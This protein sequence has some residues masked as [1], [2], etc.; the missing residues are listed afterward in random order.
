[1][2]ILRKGIKSHI[3]SKMVPLNSELLAL[4]IAPIFSNIS[5]RVK[6]ETTEIKTKDE[7]IEIFWDLMQHSMPFHK[8]A[9]INH[10]YNFVFLAI[11]SHFE[12]VYC[13]NAV[14]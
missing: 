6:R 5:H 3:R 1:M 13:E 8:I 11:L 7:Y 14:K 12:L 10:K 2:Q 9:R 4:S